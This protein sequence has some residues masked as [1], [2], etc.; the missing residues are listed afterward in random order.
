MR[1]KSGVVRESERVPRLRAGRPSRIPPTIPVVIEEWGKAS[2]FVVP[3]EWRST[4]GP[5]PPG[6]PRR[7]GA[8]STGTLAAYIGVENVR[9]RLRRGPVVFKTAAYTTEEAN[10]LVRAFV[11]R[12]ALAYAR[13]VR[14]RAKRLKLPPVVY[15]RT[16]G[17]GSASHAK[18]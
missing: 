6:T 16:A 18:S 1:N 17:S 12:K 7:K 9:D 14:S 5:V 13:A 8:P 11:R 2:T 15:V 3:R 4:M 10:D